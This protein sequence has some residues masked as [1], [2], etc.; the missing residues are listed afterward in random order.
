MSGAMTA[1]MP[2]LR[3]PRRSTDRGVSR[4]S[5]VVGKRAARIRQ[6]DCGAWS[7]ECAQLRERRREI[8]REAFRDCS[9]PDWGGYGAAPADPWAAAWGADVL[10][11]FPEGLG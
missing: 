3:F 1:V 6:D 11:A 2:G 8:L 7:G 5:Q 10:D 9:E 4:E